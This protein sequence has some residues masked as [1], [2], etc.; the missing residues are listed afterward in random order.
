MTRLSLT[1]RLALLLAAFSFVA[2]A[3]LGSALYVALGRQLDLRDDGAL[4][5]RVEQIRALLHDL[6]ARELVRDKPQLFGNMLGNTESLLII[7]PAGGA[8]LLEVNP[9]RRA[10]P[11]VT[12]LSAD[13]ALSLH[14]VRRNIMS[15]GTP[16][17]YTAVLST[18][19]GGGPALEILSGR[20]LNERTRILRE[21][22][23]KIILF[24][25]IMAVLAAG[26]AYIL[27]RRGLAPLHR[28]ARQTAS[29][30]VGT[31][32]VRLRRD[33]AP[34]ELDA[35]I[36]QFNAMLVRLERGFE[37]LKQVSADMAHDLRT[38]INNLLGQTEVGLGQVREPQ[39]YQRLLGSHF[40]E[41]QRLSR[42]MDN[43]LFLAR[44]E[45]A[46]DAL[47]CTELDVANELERVCD[48]FEDVA[49]ERGVK[50]DWTG[51]GKIRADGSLLRRALANLLDNAVRFAEPDS[52]IEI[53]AQGQARNMVIKV[54][55]R[56]VDIPAEHLE[57]IFERFFRVDPSRQRSSQ[58]SGLGLSIVRSIMQLHKGRCW[59]ESG[60]GLTCFYLEFPV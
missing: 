40:E 21:Y 39:Y 7:R 19:P 30:G 55:N 33:D 17:I 9:G 38:P 32:S 37:Q 34:A 45:H 53:S 54:L 44:T 12:P 43:M 6:D 1:T 15:D 35:L 26:L 46:E 4:L 13:E 28:L 48:Y 59:V 41:L 22:R 58:S 3:S 16:F 11:E 60:G 20:L 18:A 25:S 49:A 24:S 51:H 29:I 31:L 14:D 47:Q 23:D 36:Y 27:A 50:L 8:P 2:L 52:T 42:M 57:S 5:A 10:L 56:G